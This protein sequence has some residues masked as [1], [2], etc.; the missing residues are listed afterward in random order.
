MKGLLKG[1][2]AAL[3][4]FF[5]GA[6]LVWGLIL[7]IL[8]QLTMLER[9]IT[10]PKRGLD[11]SVAL[12]LSRDAQTCISVLKT[13]EM[14][15]DAEAASAGG[16]G[17]PSASGMAVPSSS[18]MAVPSATGQTPAQATRPYILPCDRAHT[19]K[20]L[21]RANGE[22]SQYLDTLYG[23][24]VMAVSDA[25]TVEKQIATAEKISERAKALFVD[26]KA[27]E[28]RA[29]PYT[30]ANFGWLTQARMIPLSEAQKTIEDAKLSKKLIGLIGLRFERDGKVYERIGLTTLARTLSF[31]IAATALA[32]L[33]CYPMAYKVAL[34]T[35]P[36]RAVWLFLGLVIP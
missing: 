32:L 14:Q 5:F 10:A 3:S 16:M 36:E 7:I 19:H 27:R 12:S 2:G 33:L 17:I 20:S 11:S 15:P 25:D 31:A 22:P 1:Y 21:V 28:A 30:L 29:T 35:T 4:A 6:V 18:G 23:L 13:Y 9:A 24:P 8:P 26:L 34:A